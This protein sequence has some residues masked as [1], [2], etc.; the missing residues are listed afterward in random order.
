MEL[1][2]SPSRGIDT[3]DESRRASHRLSCSYTPLILVFTIIA[4][5]LRN[6]EIQNRFRQHIAEKLVNF[7][8]EFCNPSADGSRNA[9]LSI[10]LLDFRTFFD[11]LNFGFD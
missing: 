4:C 6:P 1:L 3:S 2:A 10:I 8:A 9:E 11:M 7:D 5:S